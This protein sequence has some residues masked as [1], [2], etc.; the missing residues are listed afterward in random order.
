M[1]IMVYKQQRPR[2][3]GLL[4]LLLFTAQLLG[5]PNTVGMKS[6]YL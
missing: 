6:G 4:Q 2:P 3:A 5:N 1:I